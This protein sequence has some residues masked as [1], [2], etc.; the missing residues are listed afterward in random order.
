MSGRIIKRPGW[1]AIA[2]L[3]VLIACAC[4][5]PSKGTDMSHSN[6][7]GLWQQSREVAAAGEVGSLGDTYT[8][9]YQGELVTLHLMTLGKTSWRAADDFYKLKAR[10]QDST[11]QYLT[12]VGQWIPLATFDGAKFVAAG[13]GKRREYARITPEQVADFSAGILAPDRAPFDY[14][15]SMK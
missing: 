13:D 15:R 2:G 11:L 3:L 10:W 8:F 14:A 9:Q 4:G 12:P 5:H 1:P 7:E 6:A